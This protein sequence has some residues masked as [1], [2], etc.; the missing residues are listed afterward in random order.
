MATNKTQEIGISMSD[1]VGNLISARLVDKHLT[2]KSGKPL[3]NLTLQVENDEQPF[4]VGLI[5]KSVIQSYLKK[6]FIDEETNPSTIYFKIP[7]SKLIHQ[8]KPVWINFPLE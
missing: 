7:E 4:V 1:L 3:L 5:G 8:E 6:G 2:E